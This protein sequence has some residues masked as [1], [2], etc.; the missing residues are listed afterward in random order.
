MNKKLLTYASIGAA[1]AAI[2]SFT[3]LGVMG[4]A[5]IGLGAIAGYIDLILLPALFIC[6]IL[7][8]YARS[9]SA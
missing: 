6:V 7:I 9:G 8:G 4:M 2:L 5:A 1:T 3:P